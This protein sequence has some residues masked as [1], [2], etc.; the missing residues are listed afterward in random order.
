MAE[1][2]EQDRQW[3][4]SLL[5]YVR[6]EAAIADAL[7]ASRAERDGLDGLL[8]L[9]ARCVPAVNGDIGEW[10]KIVDDPPVSAA[11]PA[12]ARQRIA[13]GKALLADIDRALGGKK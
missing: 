7:A 13:E 9:L 10:Q 3:A 6:P 4:R 2:T 5:T 8:A 1:V 11:G 12:V